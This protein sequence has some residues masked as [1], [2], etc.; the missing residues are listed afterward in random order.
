MIP[1]W[2]LGRVLLI[3]T[4]APAIACVRAIRFSTFS[5]FASIAT[6]PRMPVSTRARS[7]N[8]SMSNSDVTRG[9]PRSSEAR[10]RPSPPTPRMAT[11]IGS[12]EGFS[13]GLVFSR[14][15]NGQEGINGSLDPK[16]IQRNYHVDSN[17]SCPKGFRPSNDC[18]GGC[19][20]RI[21]HWHVR[22]P[23]QDHADIGSSRDRRRLGDGNEAVLR[24]VDD[25][26][27]STERSEDGRAIRPSGHGV[28]RR[29][30]AVRASLFDQ[31]LGLMPPCGPSPRPDEFF[32]E[33]REE[34]LRPALADLL[35][36]VVP[37]L[38]RGL[39]IGGRPRGDQAEAR[40]LVG[41]SLGEGQGDVSAETVSRDRDPPRFERPDE[42]RHFVRV[43]L[44]RRPAE[45]D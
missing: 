34:D 38:T 22:C 29:H 1:R 45:F 23:L 37:P 44:D 35:D 39:A 3:T 16:A 42:P 10:V 8:R 13:E 5:C 11:R 24:A 25:E 7:P 12:K 17:R 9:S 20:R 4:S 43:D 21:P 6:R 19:L 33:A 27:R 2:Y 14:W 36:R 30:H 18:L 15:F 40:D 32:R 26:P 31:E 41:M 28:E